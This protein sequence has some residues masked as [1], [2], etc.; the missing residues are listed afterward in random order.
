MGKEYLIDRQLKPE[1][2]G[3]VLEQLRNAN[4]SPTSMIDVSDGLASDLKHI[5]KE[6]NVGCRIYEDKIP[7]DY[8][9]ATT[10]EEFNMNLTTAALNGGGRL[11]TSFYNSYWRPCKG[12]IA[13]KYSPDRLYHGEQTG[14]IPYCKRWERIPVDC[15]RLG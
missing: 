4:I 6:S 1:A 7:I 3:E 2:P 11:R 13:Q 5:C 8:Q 9:T 12:S 10:C 15:A 14:R